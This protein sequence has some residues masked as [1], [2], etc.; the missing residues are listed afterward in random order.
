[1]DGLLVGREAEC[2]A[3][4]RL[5]A[6]SPAGPVPVVLV[7]GEA[8]AGKTTLVE[9]VLA[10]LSTPVLRGRAV[11]WACPAYEV[12]ASALRP[13]V[14]D[15]AQPLPAVLAQI[16]PELGAQPAESSPAA[17]A[18]A[19]CSVL[20][21]VAADRTL[22]LFLDDLQWADEASLDFLAALADAARGLPVVLVGCYRSDELPRGHRLRAVRALL[23]RN[24][25]LTEIALGPLGDDDVTHLLAGLWGAAP[26]PALAAVVAS[27]ADGLPFAVEELAFALRDAG[28]LDFRDGAVA[29]AGAGAAPVPE[30]IREAVLLRASRLAV[31]ERALLETAAVAG[32]EFDIDI[33]LAAGG[34]A[35][36]PDGFT[37]SGLL[38]EARDGRA[39]FRHPLT[40]EAAYADI[41][42]SRRR[43]LHRALASTLA[44][45]EAA[46][47]LIAVHLLAARDFGLARRPLLAAAEE[48]YAVHAY[49]DAARA[50]RTAL[51][52]W[53]A[54]EQ[55]DSR[56]TVIDR[57]ARCAEM[58][59]EYADAVMLLRELA[60]GHERRGDSR[61][62]AGSGRRLALAYE[63]RGQWESALTARE[64]AAAAF[65]A[66]G[67]PAEAAIDR[68]AMA[69]H[70]RSAASFSA[71]LTTLNAAS[72]DAQACGR[73]DLLLR[74]QGLRGNVL[75][76]QGQHRDGIAAVREALDQ[77]LAAS[78]PD[79]AAELQQRLADALEHSGDY[80][81][82]T[83]AYAAAYQYCDAHGA[84]AVGQLC[85]ACAS[86]VLFARGEWDRTTGICEDVLA[87][88]A[89]PHA[90]A[91][92]DG[93]LG[94]VHAMR[95]AAKLGRPHLLECNLTATR[96]ELTA[97]ELLSSWGLCIL[98]DA[99]GAVTDAADRARQVLARLARTQERHYS[100]PILQWTATF[101]TERG[102]TADASACAAALMQIAE[103]TARPEA[104]AALAHAR[105]ETLLADQ[106]AAAAHELSR[107]AEMFSRLDLPLQTA[108]A[109]RRAAAVTVRLGE[110]A[111]ARELLHAAHATADQLG[112]RHLRDSC[113]AALRQLGETPRRHLHPRRVTA[114]LTSREL[115]VMDLVSQGNTSRQVGHALFISPRTVE[116]HVNGS[117]QKLQCRTRAEAVRRLTELGVLPGPDMIRQEPG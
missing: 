84:D 38:T 61:G 105:G 16:M 50:L 3:L 9:H 93:L 76:R 86:F 54:G 83:A 57:L 36:W 27:R 13:V 107:A 4:G 91:V 75:A 20:A 31:G 23:R 80:Q 48:H 1:M 40:Q 88:A 92:G 62:L 26:Q 37:A 5:L 89:A 73:T 35:A 47:A 24:N 111:R 99:A 6:V 87:S 113:T 41:P 85:R 22:T 34:A 58:C 94:L 74:I 51:E 60:D 14:R 44:G 43:S 110:H 112:A 12:V 29:L 33:V 67:I 109:Q 69:A 116:M 18:A 17:L 100:V 25:R 55:D 102:L 72:A 104:I 11:A 96:I 70:L 66:A 59:S 52:H 46:P 45:H 77:A 101:F 7:A 19:V 2:A 53:P 103:A 106:P 8:G 63:L 10:T 39:A 71:T 95:G 97:M 42:W 64:A 28:R 117:M 65:S 78:L 21:A 115:D 82:A 90:R 56:L 49:R 32:I 81:A 98:D 114:G 30:G 108:Q 79:T 15:A 68:L